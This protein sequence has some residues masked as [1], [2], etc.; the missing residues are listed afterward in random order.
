MNPADDARQAFAAHLGPQKYDDFVYTLNTRCRVKGRVFYWQEAAVAA[1]QEAHPEH[2]GWDWREALRVCPVHGLP[3]RP[4]VVP[5]SR[6]PYGMGFGAAYLAE[7]R[8]CH[9]FAFSFVTYGEQ[10]GAERRDADV[11]YCEA[12]R[13][14]EAACPMPRELSCQEMLPRLVATNLKGGFTI[15]AETLRAAVAKGDELLHGMREATQGFSDIDGRNALRIAEV[16]GSIDTPLAV[17]YLRELFLSSNRSARVAGTLGLVAKGLYPEPLGDEC[18]LFRAV[19]SLADPEDEAWGD[20]SYVNNA[21]LA[22]GLT[23]TPAAL[24][25]LHEVLSEPFLSHGTG[26]EG[27]ACIALARIGDPSSGP[28]LRACLHEWH[29]FPVIDAFRALLCLGDAAAVPL[30]ARRLEQLPEQWDRLFQGKT[31][32]DLDFSRGRW[33]E[34]MAGALRLVTG[35]GHGS[36]PAP[37]RLWWETAGARWQIPETFRLPFDEQ[38]ELPADVGNLK[39]FRAN[40]A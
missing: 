34:A 40:H 33:A 29:F 26:H 14:A 11:L 39:P 12:C 19:R 5:F 13:R 18:L 4:D 36:D 8:R 21:I 30:L 37:W 28:V 10:A 7:R 27:A 3:L 24:P 2:R 32:P 35:Q 38:P 31:S 25:P 22:L 16:L 6:G 1:F 23:Q 9:P 20:F 15:S 17:T